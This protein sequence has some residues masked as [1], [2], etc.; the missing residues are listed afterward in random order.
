MIDMVRSLLPILPVVSLLGGCRSSPEPMP[1]VSQVHVISVHVRDPATFDAV[2]LFFRDVLR[3]PRI[4]GEPS[5][6][7][8]PGDR[9]LYAGFSAG[10]AYLE[11]CGPYKAEAP[12]GPGRPARFHGL[13]FAPA[14]TIAAAAV[15]LE[16]RKIAHTAAGGTGG[17]PR[18]LYLAGAS[19]GKQ[20]VSI[21]EIQDQEDRANLRFLG[22]SLE[23]AGG[24]ALRVRRIEEVWIGCAGEADK[25][26]WASLL[27]PAKPVDG[28]WRIGNGPA[29]RLVPG[30]EARIDAVVLQVESLQLAR[31]A[32][33]G[34]DLMGTSGPES[35]ELDPAKTWGLR[36]ILKGAAGVAPSR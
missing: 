24:G 27:L 33:A 31:V 35:I 14:T 15:E 11:P 10:N 22:P 36:V 30:D 6:P 20:A 34:N 8:D 21:W 29:L 32:L 13:T 28:L 25:A 19:S 17:H 26:R 12:Y 7:E 9:T 4:Y 23:E 16:R 3:L 5:S 1:A 18:F 2:F